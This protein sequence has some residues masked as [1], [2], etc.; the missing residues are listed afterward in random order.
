MRLDIPKFGGEDPHQWIFNIQE[1]FNFHQTPEMQRLQI[2]GFC[3]EAEASEWFRW[4]KRNR[5]I[6]GWHDFLEKFAQRFGT[7]H[8][9]DP[10]AELAKL[11]QTGTVA[12]FQAAF[13]KL[14]N[15][16][17]GV[18]ETQLVSY[19]IGGLKPHVRRELLLAR[20]RTVLAAFELAKAHEARYNELMSECRTAYRG[21]PRVP[22]THEDTRWQSRGTNFSQVTMPSVPTSQPA[23]TTLGGS[24]VPKFLPAPTAQATSGL[25]I[26]KYTLAEIRERRDKGLCFHCDQKY[27]VGHRCNEV[28]LGDVS[29]A[30]YHVRTGSPLPYALV[31]QIKSFPMRGMA[32]TKVRQLVMSKRGDLH[33]KDLLSPVALQDP[34]PV[35]DLYTKGQENYGQ[36]SLVQTSSMHGECLRATSLTLQEQSP[37]E[38]CS[39]GGDYEDVWREHFRLMP[40]YN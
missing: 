20:P 37:K 22:S 2:A 8:F 33:C 17:I 23:T 10:L 40:H 36:G 12:D 6:F 39:E 13:E 3:L 16:V 5:M 1:Y 24:G 34:D 28:I 11:T 38:A 27:S 14:L 19:V 32:N 21:S 18:T 26:R 9:E 25:P 31:G 30:Q 7:T 15:R 35:Q 4:M 29:H